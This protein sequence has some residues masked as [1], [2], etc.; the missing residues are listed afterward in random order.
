MLLSSFAYAQDEEETASMLFSA[1]SFASED[2][3][4]LS[5]DLDLPCFKPKYEIKLPK[6]AQVCE[7]NQD[8][9]LITKNNLVPITITKFDDLPIE[10]KTKEAKEYFKTPGNKIGL[11]LHKLA[12]GKG[13]ETGYNGIKISLE[14]N[15]DD[16]FYGL[17][18]LIFEEG[19]EN[20]DKRQAY[21][22]GRTSDLKIAISKTLK[23]GITLSGEIASRL[24][25][26]RNTDPRDYSNVKVIDDHFVF[27]DSVVV[28]DQNGDLWQYEDDG[29]NKKLDENWDVTER[30]WRQYFNNIV[31][32]KV[33]IDNIQ[34]DKDLFYKTSLGIIH[35]DSNNDRGFLYGTGIQQDW[36]EVASYK[37]LNYDDGDPDQFGVAAE[38]LL[39]LQKNL[40]FGKNCQNR[41]RAMAGLKGRVST[42]AKDSN[43][44]AQAGVQ[45]FHQ[46]PGSNT[47]WFVKFNNDFTV[48]AANGDKTGAMLESEVMIGVAGKKM[49][50]ETGLQARMGDLPSFPKYDLD[51]D[52]IFKVK[53][54]GFLFTGAGKEK[55]QKKKLNQFR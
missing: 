24:Y 38:F 20:R 29:R 45:F 25:T 23:N 2:L 17:W 52:P 43:I 34:Q 53:V 6:E 30:Y 5:P 36:H 32:V 28:R 44:G 47:V 33:G 31:E 21:D 8:I 50:L 55:K 49:A 51:K 48:H 54:T 14:G 13:Y 37:F 12:P 46:K 18:G 16:I 1:A 9:P 27:D 26:K 19:Q 41:I 39:G 42:L 35:T 10:L 40:I 15:N 11:M 7:F 3:N 4:N 22:H